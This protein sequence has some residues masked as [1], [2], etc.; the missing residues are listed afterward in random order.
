MTCE[1]FEPNP[2]VGSGIFTLEELRSI[3]QSKGWCPYYFAR[4]AMK[5]ASVVVFSYQY[6]LNGDIFKACLWAKSRSIFF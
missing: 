3:G 2:P 6:V 5:K 1:W 4:A